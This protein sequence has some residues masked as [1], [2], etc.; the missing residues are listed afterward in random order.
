[1]IMIWTS[2][3]I[4][5]IVFI[6]WLVFKIVMFNCVCTLLDALD[7]RQTSYI[8]GIKSQNFK[9]FSF[10]HAVVFAQPIEARR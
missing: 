1:M 3:F 9:C 4:I 10:R 2:L 6:L 5:V 7:H 8:S